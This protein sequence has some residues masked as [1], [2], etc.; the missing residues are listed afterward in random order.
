MIFI[1]EA[2]EFLHDIVEDNLTKDLRGDR[3]DEANKLRRAI[4]NEVDSM[5]PLGKKTKDFNYEIVAGRSIKTRNPSD[6]NAKI[7]ELRILTKQAI[8]SG[9]SNSEFQ[10]DLYLISIDLIFDFSQNFFFLILGKSLIHFFAKFSSIR[11]SIIRC[12][13]GF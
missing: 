4:R 5:F 10:I 11:L 9:I 13:K 7:E 3:S 12:L 2:Q 1:I 8:F 6:F